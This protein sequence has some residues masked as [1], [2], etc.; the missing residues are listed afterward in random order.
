MSTNL[1]AGL[2]GAAGDARSADIRP[3]TMQNASVCQ[4]HAPE[5]HHLLMHGSG[6]NG[7]HP[8]CLQ[9]CPTHPMVTSFQT[10]TPQLSV[11]AALQPSAYRFSLLM[12]FAASCNTHQ[13]KHKELNQPLKQNKTK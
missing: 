10:P 6:R 8:C 7:V 5:M 1:K 13:T 3:G 9:G 2:L 11:W 4:S 12:H